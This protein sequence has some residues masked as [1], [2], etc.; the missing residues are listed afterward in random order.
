MTTIQPGLIYLTRTEWGTRTDIPRLGHPVNRLDRT[1]AIMHHT[2]IIDNDATPNRWETLAEVKAKM[3]QL[4]TIRPDLGLDVPYNFV[5]FHMADGSL[6]ICEGRGFDRTGAHTHAHNTRGIATAGQGNFQ[7]GQ[8]LTSYIDHWSRW[9]GY[10]KFDMG[11]ENLGSVH[12]ARGIAFGHLDFIS[13][14]CP[15]DNLYAIIPQLTFQ[16]AEED[17][18]AKF[19]Q[20]AGQGPLFVTDG[21]WKWGV[22]SPAVRDDLIKTG[23]V[24]GGVIQLEAATFDRL[25]QTHGQP[26][27]SGGITFEEA[28]EASKMANRDGTG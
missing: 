24:S 28:V 13:T 15:G 5:A 6:I 20:R 9:W 16:A 23:L 27:A 10:Q 18:M 2:V 26:A 17:D 21:I 3:V 11:M 19:I 7:I 1:E 12:P 8:S 14:G 22:P 25:Q 4:Q